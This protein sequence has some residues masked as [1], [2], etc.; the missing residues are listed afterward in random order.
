MTEKTSAMFDYITGKTDGDDAFLKAQLEHALG[1]LEREIEIG[2]ELRNE[3]DRLQREFNLLRERY[4]AAE[5]EIERLRK[6]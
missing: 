6:C 1:A 3:L 5:R 2:E 4:E